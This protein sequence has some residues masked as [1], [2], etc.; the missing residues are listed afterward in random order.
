MN[1]GNTIKKGKWIP[2][3]KENFILKF[4]SQQHRTSKLKRKLK[5]EYLANEIDLQFSNSFSLWRVF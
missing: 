3:C 5:L 4:F 1:K 2:K